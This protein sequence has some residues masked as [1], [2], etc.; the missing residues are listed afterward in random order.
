MRIHAKVFLFQSFL[1][2]QVF[3]YDFIIY[4]NITHVSDSS[5]VLYDVIN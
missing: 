4:T 3:N 1:W 2:F 5:T